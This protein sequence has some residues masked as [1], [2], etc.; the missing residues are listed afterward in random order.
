MYINIPVL[1]M[2]L[3]HFM[4]YSNTPSNT[5]ILQAILPYSQANF[6]LIFDALNPIRTF[7][8]ELHRSKSLETLVTNPESVDSPLV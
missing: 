2:V 7:S 8:T 6:E 1:L 5:P 4:S 3:Q